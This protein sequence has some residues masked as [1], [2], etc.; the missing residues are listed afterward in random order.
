MLREFQLG[1]AT[2]VYA[3]ASDRGAGAV[4][5]QR[6]ADNSHWHMV[7]CWSH[8]FTGSEKG[9]D[10]THKETYAIYW[11]ICREWYWMLQPCAFIA[12]TDHMPVIF[13]LSKHM[14]QLKG[15]E[16]RW[17]H[18]LSQFNVKIAH[19]PGVQNTVADALSRHL[20]DPSITL[21]V[22]DLYAGG[23]TN[24][25]GLLFGTPPNVK[26]A[27][28]PC[29]IDKWNQAVIHKLLADAKKRCP[30]KFIDV[31]H[32]ALGN[33]VRQVVPDTLAS[34]I[35]SGAYSFL[36][37]GP[38]CQGFSRAN[39]QALGLMDDREGFSSL[40]LLLPV[41]SFFHVEN[42][43]F[44]SRFPTHVALINNWFG[45]DQELVDL[46]AFS[47]QNRIRAIWASDILR[48]IPP[49]PSCP[50]ILDCLDSGWRLAN[51]ADKCGTLMTRRSYSDANNKVTDSL[52]QTRN[53]NIAERERIVGFRVDDTLVDG[54]SLA[55]RVQITGN[56]IPVLYLQ[57]LWGI[58]CS[59][60]HGASL[61]TKS[62]GVPP[63]SFSFLAA[64]D[65][66]GST[67][68][69]QVP[70]DQVLDLIAYYHSNFA[71][72]G[73]DK[74]YHLLVDA[75]YSFSEMR[76]HIEEFVASCHICQKSKRASNGSALPLERPY[77]SHP[78]ETVHIDLCQVEPEFGSGH[79]SSFIIVVDR[80]SR[81]IWAAPCVH[82]P[83]ALE[84]LHI[85]R[86]S[87][88]QQTGYPWRMI[89]DNA[90]IFQS[91]DWKEHMARR[92][93][94][95]RYSTAYHSAGNGLA[96]RGNQILWSSCEL[97][98]CK[99]GTGQKF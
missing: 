27:Y 60:L 42:V 17:A 83:T 97:H 72:P 73:V 55:Q 40:V 28:Y 37:A 2:I 94:I 71:H 46:S 48:D 49:P 7:A 19:T 91:E 36:M 47:A 29:E 26:I 68:P 77:D 32:A 74:T 81:Y 86:Q 76:R 58:A 64:A 96:E 3:D 95:V 78:L 89:S 33:D 31:D 88:F 15:Y 90:G 1:L 30:G 82:E 84:C 67:E 66:S 22:F 14:D 56:A 85:L 52:G 39:S 50:V 23:G 93:C 99:G 80:A 11:S 92:S 20:A 63:P 9:W 62:R 61:G 24:I 43:D 65:A 4:L 69:T 53:F 5:Y 41:V 98:A 75:G 57:T 51:G 12:Y 87:M 6:D 34:L 13:I 10:T 8:V 35:P 16:W 44:A 70:D 45:V 18:R 54:I 38:Q 21:C 25:L 79:N 59:R